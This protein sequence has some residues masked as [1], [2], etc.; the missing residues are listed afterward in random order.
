MNKSFLVVAAI[1]LS[2]A[3]SIQAA[4]PNIL[5]ILAD[6]LGY[7]DLSCYG[8]KDIRTPNLD[9]L[10]QQGV[11][12]TDAYSAACVCTPTRAAFITGRYPQHFGFDW[13][14]RYKEKDRGLPAT[15]PTLAKQL[16]SAGYATALLGK[17]HLGYKPEFQPRAHGFDRFFG[18][19]AADLDFYSHKDANG[20]PGL[21]DDELQVQMGGYLTDLITQHAVG[22]ISARKRQSLAKETR[23]FPETRIPRSQ[24]KPW[25]LFV[26]YNAPHWP[27]Q[28]PDKVEER[29]KDNYEPEHG[30]RADYVKMV[31]RMDSGIGQILDALDK[32]KQADNTLVIFT[33]D[34]GGERLSDNGPFF[35]GKYTLWEGGIRVP[36]IVRWPGHLSANHI[37]HQPVITMDWTASILSA[38]GVKPDQPLDGDNV[39]PLLKDDA[40]IRNRTFYWRLPRPDDKYGM[41]ALR[42]GNWKYVYDREME[43]L[44]DLKDD[45]GERKNLAKEK[46]DVVADLRKRWTEWDEKLPT[47]K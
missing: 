47:G 3:T 18:F 40:T 44:F 43:M 28:V 6:D 37:S 42:D 36:A 21:Y 35:H 1:A 9:K 5:F 15:T 26:S 25:F 38:A 41:K 12:L 24:D 32:S 8:S 34:N 20:D 7:G 23:I 11:R 31:E 10:A 19:L 16:K 30:T 33:S 29:N 17:W 14:I 2:F 13:V 39:L 27:F 22:W 46:P 45:P 4:P